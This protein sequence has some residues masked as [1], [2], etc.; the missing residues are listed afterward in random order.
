LELSYTEVHFNPRYFRELRVKLPTK[1]AWG[2]PPR[3]HLTYVI[4]PYDVNS[5]FVQCLEPTE[6]APGLSIKCGLCGKEMLSLIRRFNGETIHDNGLLCFMCSHV[7]APR[8]CLEAMARAAYEYWELDY[9]YETYV[10]ERDA[11][12]RSYARVA[13]AMERFAESF[14]KGPKY[15]YV[16][17][18]GITEDKRITYIVSKEEK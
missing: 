13:E 10:R 4:R 11:L 16:T 17:R 18:M 5:K 2:I 7:T 15:K 8:F 3:K 14:G 1:R 12:E 6:H 9:D